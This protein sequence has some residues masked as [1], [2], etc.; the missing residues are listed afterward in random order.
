[1][2]RSLG[3]RKPSSPQPLLV[4]TPR[5]ASKKPSR[6]GSSWSF[7]EREVP[8]V[9]PQTEPPGGNLGRRPW[10]TH[11]D[12]NSELPRY[13]TISSFHLG[14][15]APAPRAL[16]ARPRPRGR[17]LAL[18]Q[19]RSPG[20]CD[21]HRERIWQS[22]A[23]EWRTVRGD[24]ICESFLPRPES[25]AGASTGPALLAVPATSNRPWRRPPTPT[26]SAPRRTYRKVLLE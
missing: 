23:R 6:Y 19:S 11:V 3:S 16:R 13:P 2:D 10:S 7:A 14:P 4:A 22:W 9:P 15:E 17:V 12:L 26:R 25:P 21:P 8:V 20:H 24:S 1:M 5:C 18:H